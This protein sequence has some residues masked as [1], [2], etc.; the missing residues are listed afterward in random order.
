VLP[1]ENRNSSGR[2]ELEEL[3]NLGLTKSIKNQYADKL[4][5]IEKENEAHLAQVRILE[6]RKSKTREFIPSRC[7]SL[8]AA[9]EKALSLSKLKKED[10]TKQQEALGYYR[11]NQGDPEQEEDKAWKTTGKV[12]TS[13]GNSTSTKEWEAPESEQEQAAKLSILDK[14]SEA[15]ASKDSPDGVKQGCS[16]IIL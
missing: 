12:H 7:A 16:C 11:S 2:S 9:D 14:K 1:Q 8:S 15:T 10:R 5:E 13:I 4:S 3:R 6:E